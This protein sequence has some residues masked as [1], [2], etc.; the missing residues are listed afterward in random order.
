MDDLAYL[1]IAEAGRRFRSRQLSPTQLAHALLERI[2]RLDPQYNAFLL[3]TAER[4][5]AQ[6]EQAER[7][8]AR[9]QDRGP[10]HGIPYA[11]KDIF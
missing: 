3:V 7:E 9:G 8:L 5:I 10:F 4:A 2:E 6:A 1:G 11:L